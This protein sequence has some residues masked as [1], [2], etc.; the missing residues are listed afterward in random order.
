MKIEFIV[1]IVL[2]VFFSYSC[3]DP[4]QGGNSVPTCEWTSQEDIAV[5]P[6]VLSAPSGMSS[7]YYGQIPSDR[8]IR[9][10]QQPLWKGNYLASQNK[11]KIYGNLISDGSACNGNNTRSYDLPSNSSK[12]G[13]NYLKLAVPAQ[14]FYGTA[15]MTIRSDD[16]QSS[17]DPTTAEY[18][19]WSGSSSNPDYPTIYGTLTGQRRTW[20]PSTGKIV[21]SKGPGGCYYSNGLLVCP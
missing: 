1:P 3:K 7:Y 15:K 20:N 13:P 16:Y 17:S 8:K 12:I 2:V 5:N 11:G 10:L 14:G 18:V 6:I 21:I 9:N 19:M 4:Y